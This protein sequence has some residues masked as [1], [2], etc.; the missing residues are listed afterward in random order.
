MRARLAPL[1]VI[2]GVGLLLRLLFVG[3]TGFHSDVESFEAWTIALRDFA[4]WE[5][6][7][8]ENFADYSPGYLVVLWV[9]AKIYAILPG[10]GGDPAHGYIVLRVLVKLPAIAMDLVDASVIYLI[11]RRYAAERVA[12]FAAAMLALNPAAIYIS[13]YWGQIDSVSWG[14]VLIAVWLLLRAG[15]EPAKLVPRLTLAWLALAFSV[16]VKPQ[17]ATVG[18]LFLA[19]PFAAGDARLRARRLAAT[20]AGIV[21]SIALAGI[22]S[23]VFHP[24]PDVLG[25]LFSRYVHGS[26]VYAYT[27]VNA[28]NLYAITQPF[29][30]PDSEPVSLFGIAAGSR[31]LWGIVLVLAAT[32]LIVWRYLQRRDERALLEAAMLCALAFFVFATRMHERY[33]YGA[34]LFAMPL[35]A[36][37]RAG[38]WSSVVLTITMYFNLAYS[39]AYQTVMESRLTGVDA[40]NL[41]P[42]ISRPASLANLVLFFVLGATYLGIT[43]PRD[44][45]AALATGARR[46]FD[47][48]EGVASLTRRDWWLIAGFIAVAFAVAIVHFGWPPEKYFDEIYFAKSGLQYL[49]G[50]PQFEWTHPPFTKEVIAVSIWLFGGAGHGDRSEGWRFLNILI[51][52]LEVGVVYAFAKRLTA[53]TVYAALA[54]LCIAFDGFHFAESRIATGE[55]T[56]ATLITI[57]L[58]AFYRYWLA[59]QIAARPRLARPWGFPFVL[60]MALGIPLALAFSWLT[61]LQPPVHVTVI[62]NLIG[63]TAGA[64]ATSYAVAFLYAYLG[65][66]LFARLVVQRRGARNGTT[67]SYADGTIVELGAASTA[68]VVVPPA[69]SDDPELR[70]RY[71]RDGTMRYKT[72][73]ATASFAPTRVMSVDETPYVRASDA[74]LWLIVTVIALGLLVASKWNGFFDLGVLFVVVASVWAQRFLGRRALYGN[75]NGFD[76]SIVLPL[77]VFACATIY[78]ITYIPTIVR[79]GGH[80]L[81]DIIALQQQMFWYHHGV[82][83]QT[84]PYRS[85]WWQWPIMEI[86]IVYWYKDFRTGAALNIDSM[87]CVGE[88]I[89]IPNP[90]VF[91]LGLVSVPYTAWLAWRE[92]NKGY[93][94]LAITYFLQW[95]PWTQSPRELFEYHFFPNLVPIVLCNAIAVK[96]WLAGMADARRMRW[97]GGYATAVVLVFAFFYPVLAGVSLPYEQWRW[98]MIPDT[99]GISG[100]SWILPHPQPPRR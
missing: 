77:M 92:R 45:L 15:D 98:R 39:L 54:A 65:V 22:V 35:I 99:L 60:T 96:H 47:P 64:D 29:W 16:L 62:T 75:P 5:F 58:Y 20:G 89:A 8:K 41:W 94:L 97:I 49:K 59:A 83:D 46:W 1:W 37:G 12:L 44:V 53:S 100:V 84:H 31:A 71:E 40:T 32:A 4:P 17:G 78:A 27:S 13:S 91:L 42:S 74:R 86:P 61:N 55:I 23:L 11:A 26:G 38:V 81:A 57:T 80:T 56:I 25:W 79:A 67:V 24:A 34:F 82:A 51:G 14:L 2:L 7:A 6:Y 18:V 19:Y 36:F 69:D 68:P 28:F 87:C 63:P 73:V 70:V 30:M 72:P 21:A 95:L 90:L 66:Y 88:I 48:R 33:V 52:A 85:V 93:A 10:A 3:G 43:A 50:S 76:P 9:L